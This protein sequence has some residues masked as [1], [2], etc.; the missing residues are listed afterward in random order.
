M[1][2]LLRINLDELAYSLEELPKIYADLGGRA[3]SSQIIGQEVPPKADPIGP[4]NKLIFAAGILAGTTFPN[5]GRLSVG[6]KSPLTNGIKE[7]NVGGTAGQKLGRLGIKAI[8]VEGK[9]QGGRQI[10]DWQQG[11]PQVFEE[12]GERF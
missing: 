9:A 2:K 3:L 11:I 12:G 7:A 5:S 4:E 1:K 8:I 10:L 6:A